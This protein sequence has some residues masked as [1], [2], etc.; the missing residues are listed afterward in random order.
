MALLLAWLVQACVA[1]PVEG[2]A[3]A[4]AYVSVQNGASRVDLP[5]TRTA[6]LRGEQEPAVLQRVALLD[7]E[8]VAPRRLPQEPAAA[9]DT[10][11]TRKADAAAPGER[12]DQTDPE[13]LGLLV[14]GLGGMALTIRSRVSR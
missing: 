13:T 10:A 2:A 12:A 5:G 9:A 8:T 14:L 7:Q 4:P 1:Q 6:A 3:I 11:V